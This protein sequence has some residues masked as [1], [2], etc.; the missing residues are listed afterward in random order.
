MR[1]RK[2]ARGS[3]RPGAL[4]RCGAVTLATAAALAVL[5][6]APTPVCAQAAD[7][8]VPAQDGAVADVAAQGQGVPVLRYDGRTHELALADA[9]GGLFPAFADMMPGDTVT[10]EIVVRAEHVQTPTTLY[11]Q[12]GNVPVAVEGLGAVRV[13]VACE[14]VELAEGSLPDAGLEKPVAL[15]AF[16]ADGEVRC[17]VTLS[18]P[19]SLG[20][21]TMGAVQQLAWRVTAQEDGGTGGPGSPDGDTGG[22]GS[23]D[24]GGP[25]GGPS[26]PSSPN[27]GPGP[28]AGSPTAPG[29]SAGQSGSDAP[30][31]QT[32][33]PM[34]AVG[35]L[36]I[37]GFLLVI[38]G[39]GRLARRRRP[40][41]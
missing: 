27:G 26:N 15:A 1:E 40:F 34:P 3:W 35:I 21:E 17:G 9:P 39:R 32:G 10:Q 24:G 25:N 31:A 20:P 28:A 30:L 8:A 16:A 2:W 4:R 7:V 18:V 36:T 11:M 41:A 33:D 5:V 29:A 13:A 12:A 14:G 38:W 22:P 19:T 23:P 6:G 37:C